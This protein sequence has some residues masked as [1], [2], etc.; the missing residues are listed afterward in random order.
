M[1]E[2]ADSGSQG[3]S[4]WQRGMALLCLLAAIVE[5][6][7]LTQREPFY[8][9][10]NLPGSNAL[11]GSLFLIT[12][13]VT[14]GL[15]ALLFFFRADDRNERLYSLA[16][17]TTF[18]GFVFS[19]WL[20]FSKAEFMRGYFN[21]L[22]AVAPIQVLKLFLWQGL[23]RRGYADPTDIPDLSSGSSPGAPSAFTLNRVVCGV[24]SRQYAGAPGTSCPGCTAPVENAVPLR[25][26]RRA[27]W[28]RLW[29]APSH[30]QRMAAMGL[31]LTNV[32]FLGA[33]V[34][35]LRD[36]APVLIGLLVVDAALA[37]LVWT[38]VGV[39]LVLA[40]AGVGVLL[41]W[42]LFTP[43]TLPLLVLTQAV[44]GVSLAVLLVHRLGGAARLLAV[45]GP[46][47]Y[48][49]LVG[50]I[51]Y[52]LAAANSFVSLLVM[53]LAG[54]LEPTPVS[55]PRGRA[56]SYTLSLPPGPW[57]PYTQAQAD[58]AH[59]DVALF[60]PSLGVNMAVVVQPIPKL[61]DWPGLERVETVL[62]NALEQRKSGMVWG[63]ARELPG[64][65]DEA[66]ARPMRVRVEGVMHESV[67]ALFRRGDRLFIVEASAPARRSPDP[68]PLLEELVGALRYEPPP[69]AFLAEALAQRVKQATV[70]VL[71]PGG[72]GSGFIIDTQD[73]YSILTAQHVLRSATGQREPREA[74]V[75][76]SG[77]PAVERIAT[78]RAVDPRLDLALLQLPLDGPPRPALA[79]RGSPLAKD[80]SVVASDFPW[81]EP[82]QVGVFRSRPTLHL[83]TVK[84]LQAPAPSSY[85]DRSARL[86]LMAPGPLPRHGGGPVVDLEGAVVGMTVGAATTAGASVAVPTERLLPFVKTLGV[87]ALE[88]PASPAPSEADAFSPSVREALNAALVSVSADR[89]RNPRV[90]VVVRVPGFKKGLVLTSAW[91]ARTQEPVEVGFFVPAS[92]TWKTQRGTV[93][94]TQPYQKN[95]LALVE[96]EAFPELPEGLAL[97][98]SSRLSETDLV[99]LGGLREV[100]GTPRHL[101]RSGAM[102]GIDWASGWERGLQSPTRFRVAMSPGGVLKPGPAVDQQG[103]LVGFALQHAEE[104]NLVEF[105][106][107]EPLRELLQGPVRAV[108]ARATRELQGDCRVEFFVD[109]R[110]ELPVP[111][112][113]SLAVAAPDASREDSVVPGFGPERD[114]G[115]LPEPGGRLRLALPACPG[116]ALVYRLQLTSA[117]GVQR[118]EGRLPLPT[119]ALERTQARAPLLSQEGGSLKLRD[120][121]EWKAEEVAPSPTTPEEAVAACGRSRSACGFVTTLGAA[122]GARE[123]PRL[124]QL[125]QAACRKGQPS[126]CLG[127]AEVADLPASAPS[128]SKAGPAGARTEGPPEQQPLLP[129]V[130]TALGLGCDAGLAEACARLGRRLIRSEAREKMPAALVEDQALAVRLLNK[131]CEAGQANGCLG[132]AE[133]LVQGRGVERDEALALRKYH[134]ACLLQDAQ[135]CLKAG[136]MHQ[137]PSDLS[138]GLDRA[139]EAFREACL[140]GLEQGCAELPR[141]MDQAR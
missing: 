12:G 16:G 115:P 135:A 131:A 36:V 37:M 67:T 75:L 4:I 128:P 92:Q 91:G 124:L 58:R 65:W 21:A 83:G 105:V 102:A 51:V 99:A 68:R 42:R 84:E 86:L 88:A 9:Y 81:N 54:S 76:F 46:L 101:Q 55:L 118:V 2:H 20:Y 62:Q 45:P 39:G 1:N 72:R 133:L 108:A 116:S 103:A 141:V 114:L 90:G 30:G 34:L 18:L 47:L 31:L 134:Q 87:R 106:A 98:E 100:E 13:L 10:I 50:G 127:W 66:R 22:W 73:G 24:C 3:T 15:P 122:A 126:A 117:L 89:G 8:I 25:S 53:R 63:K 95:T 104:T 5:Y 35:L 129:E 121:M 112:T 23:N 107:T 79:F 52:S 136:N 132:L 71:T 33:H 96:V 43:D 123:R 27:G 64:T 85:P 74:R 130:R 19:L 111:R 97:Q 70:R 119:R 138:G 69:P 41:A 44:L 77:D 28:W 38:P 110:G 26:E 32:L 56:E 94:V 125:L 140:L 49:V 109:A 120:F 59:V 29:Q 6:I 57:Y 82:F 80:A 60:N 17:L 78:V 40:R 7:A 61:A 137:V 139:Y 14:F 48:A 11:L 93:L 113:V